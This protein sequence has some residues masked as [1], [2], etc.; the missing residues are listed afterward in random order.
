MRKKTVEVYADE[1]LYVSINDHY[2]EAMSAREDDLDPVTA[3]NMTWPEWDAV[4]A[5]VEARREEVQG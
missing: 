3:V 4:V 5:A 1:G 2:V